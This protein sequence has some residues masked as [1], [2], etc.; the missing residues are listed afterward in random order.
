VLDRFIAE[1]DEVLRYV[2]VTGDED[3]W[4]IWDSASISR[5]EAKR[6]IALYAAL[7]LSSVIRYDGVTSDSRCNDARD[8]TEL[9]TIGLIG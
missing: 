9:E 5:G 4:L 8:V 1:G 7:P 3:L 2:V 6:S